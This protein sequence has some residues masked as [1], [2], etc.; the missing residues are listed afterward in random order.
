MTMDELRSK[1][2]VAYKIIDDERKMRAQVFKE[3]HPKREEKLRE[4]DR[5]LEIMTEMKDVIKADLESKPEQPTLLDVPR[6]AKYG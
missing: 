2:K 5:L 6:R 4:M 3:G 1:F